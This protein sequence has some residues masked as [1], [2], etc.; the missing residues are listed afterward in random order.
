MTFETKVL[1]YNAS[2]Q[3]A[4][5]TLRLAHVVPAGAQKGNA[6]ASTVKEKFSSFGKF[7]SGMIMPNIGAFIAWGFLSAFFIE[8][9]WT[10]N[11]DFASIASA[12]LTYLIPILISAQGGYMVGG[13]RGRVMGAITVLGCIAEDTDTTMLMAAMIMGPLSGWA[14]KKLDQLLQDKIP[15]GFE[16]LYDNFSI[17]ILGMLLAMLGYVAIG[18][19]M[20]AILALLMAGVNVLINNNL[21]PLLAILI[22][23]A[24]VLFLN[25]AINHG[26]FTPIGIE[27]AAES[28]RSIMYM[29]EANPG[30][31]L[32]VLLAY[33]F[34]C[35]DDKTRQSAPGAV[36][37][38]FFGGIHEIY[39]P[40]VLMNP[41]VII[42]PIVGNMCAIFWYSIM[43]AGLVAAASPGSII[44]FLSMSPSG[45]VWINLV[46]VII[47]AAVSFVIAIPLV[48]SMP[49]N[50]SLDEANEQMREMK[51][52]AEATVISN[53]ENMHIV[54]ACDA[55]MGSSAMGAT[56][57]R[58]RIKAERPDIEVTNSS[59]DNVP[60][61]A[62]IV[63]CQRVLSERARKSAP[64][65]QIVVIDNFL[66]DPALDNLYSS[67]TELSKAN[68]LKE[69]AAPALEPEAKT[70]TA[71]AADAKKP[72]AIDRD[73]IQLGLASVDR[74]QAIRDSGE[75]LVKKG[76]VDESYVDAMVERDKLTSVY[77]GM[78]IAIPHGTGEAKDSVQK[79][80]V[81]LQQYPDGVD[82]DGEKAYLLFGI[83]GK[84]NEHLD[85]ISAICTVLEDEEVLEKMKTTD[86]V[87]WILEQLS[88]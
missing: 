79:T 73:G 64:Q 58:N 37:I 49:A 34:F 21:L 36:I 18:P 28:G 77:L 65:A 33:C 87:D 67:L 53:S 45:Y 25:N 32:G 1:K 4:P 35:K 5:Y 55:G 68:D 52:T 40:Y 62:S 20:E 16:M 50:Q 42:A 13:E 84:G 29:L 71:E 11:E 54:F 26:I 57:F 6:M 41:K 70:E 31:G 76:C 80:G 46:G 9:G 10:P 75:L 83:A 15:A 38:H 48:R 12:M 60:A 14:I 19:L 43:D 63:V 51:G 86:D 24:K 81:V 88:K 85:A 72:L 3:S 74:E 30:P 7:L 59:V 66:D 82:F 2:K 44:A 8:T 78:G 69:T 27:Q 56:R 39:F 23:P 22:E 61:D 17:G 47:A